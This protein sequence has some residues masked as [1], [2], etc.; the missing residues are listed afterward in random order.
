MTGAD[1]PRWPWINSASVCDL[2]RSRAVICHSLPSITSGR[3]SR[4]TMFDFDVMGHPFYV[5]RHHPEPRGAPTLL[6]PLI[7]KGD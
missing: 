4:S 3:D 6:L 2:D 1:R 7:V 5:I